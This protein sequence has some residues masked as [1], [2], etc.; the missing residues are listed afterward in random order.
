[1]ADAKANLILTPAPSQIGRNREEMCIRQCGWLF[2][3]HLAT[4][5]RLVK[6][7]QAEIK[8]KAE[9]NAEVDTATMQDTFLHAS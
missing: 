8:Y 5:I 4:Y 9:G 2:F 3:L 7:E 6:R 1:M